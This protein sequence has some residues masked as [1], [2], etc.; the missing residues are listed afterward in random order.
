MEIALCGAINLLLDSV[1]ILQ[2]MSKQITE[3]P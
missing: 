1:E 3:K 2:R